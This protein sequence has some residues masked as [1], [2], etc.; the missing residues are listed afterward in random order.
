MS[1]LIQVSSCTYFYISRLLHTSTPWIISLVHSSL[2]KTS[3]SSE[4]KHKHKIQ[5]Q[6]WEE[7]LLKGR[8]GG[9]QTV[10][11]RHV[12]PAS[13]LRRFFFSF[14]QCFF[15]FWC[16]CDTYQT[17]QERRKVRESL[18]WA[19]GRFVLQFLTYL[20]DTDIYISNFK[21]QIM[22]WAK[23]FIQKQLLF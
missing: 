15:F 7:M 21:F 4:P 1:C 19:L 14:F 22:Y 12:K 3:Q 2:F 13:I 20:L 16:K 10:S 8:N 23:A 11:K 5:G 18:S 6:E 17:W 9:G